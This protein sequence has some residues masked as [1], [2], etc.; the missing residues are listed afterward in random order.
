M[1]RKRFLAAAAIVLIVAGSLTAYSTS[2]ETPKSQV[3]VTSSASPEAG[4]KSATYLA[5]LSPSLVSIDPE[6]GIY[7]LSVESGIL[8]SWDYGTKSI[9]KDGTLSQE[10]VITLNERQ[11][12]EFQAAGGN[13][14]PI[15]EWQAEGLS[16]YAVIYSLRLTVDEL[17]AGHPKPNITFTAVLK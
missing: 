7:Y 16:Y 1:F 3:T 15:T 12:K 5:D 14:G 6:K 2:V 10:F 17:E 13:V 11:L 4:S 9:A 8:A